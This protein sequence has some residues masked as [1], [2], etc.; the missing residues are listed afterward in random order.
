MATSTDPRTSNLLGAL[1]LAVAD[2][3]HAAAEEAAG[4]GAAGPAALVALHEF[5]NG[6]TID[7]LRDVVGLSHSGAVRLVDRLA[8]DG[9]VERRRGSDA[10]AVSVRLTRS[11][12]ARARRVLTARSR[13][14]DEVVDGLDAD[15]QAMLASVLERLLAT[16]TEQ[17]V[18][19]RLAGDP[20]TGGWLC[21]MCDL[22]CCGR[23]EGRCPTAEAARAT[24][25]EAQVDVTKP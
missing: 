21:R 24:M 23:P 22:D 12:H 4:Y 15:E 3:V 11:G 8:A 1:G 7:E 17:R 20:P 2:R 13:V 25:A 19:A 5:R 6:G 9:L 18:Q 16:M 10:R 14:L